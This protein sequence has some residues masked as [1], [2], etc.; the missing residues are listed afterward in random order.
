M[1]PD[2]KGARQ[3]AK[4]QFPTIPLLRSIP[5][6]VFVIEHSGSSLRGTLTNLKLVRGGHLQMRNARHNGCKEERQPT[7]RFNDSEY[8]RWSERLMATRSFKTQ[9]GIQSFLG[10]N[11]NLQPG[12]EDISLSSTG[13][14]EKMTKA[15]T[16]MV[17]KQRTWKRTAK[18]LPNRCR[19][20]VEKL[21]SVVANDET[22]IARIG[23]DRLTR[24]AK[25]PWGC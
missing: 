7:N 24:W 22:R 16:I 1:P 18:Q 25:S 17:W 13:V 23:L 14:G 12:C 2:S 15:A 8:R 9:C 21:Y 4:S 3:C 6:I 5:R 11:E 19:L 20:L 10:T